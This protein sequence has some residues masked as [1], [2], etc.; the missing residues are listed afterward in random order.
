MADVPGAPREPSATH[1]HLL[2]LLF[3][4]LAATALFLLPLLRREVFVLRDHL[5]YFQPMRWFTATELRAGHLPLWNP[6]NSSGEPW[7]ANPQTGVFY[8]PAW[9]FVV[10]PFATAYV[11]FLLAHLILLGW[12]AY[13]LFARKASRSAALMGAT[14][15]MFCGPVVSLLDIST[16]LT[17]LAWFPLVLWCA[18]ERAW[19]RGGIVLALAFLAGEP[20]FAAVAALL[21]GFAAIA[22]AGSRS[23]APRPVTGAPSRAD[24]RQSA[25]IIARGLVLSALIAFGLSAV[26]LL[27]FLA[28][29]RGSDRASGFDAATILEYS[30]RLEDWL[31]VAMPPRFGIAFDPAVG[32]RFIPLVYIGVVVCALALAGIRRR[33]AGWVILFV[34]AVAVSTGP[35]WLVS[36][37]LTIFRYPARVVPLAALAL[38]ALAVAGYDRVRRGRRW[39][40]VAVVLVVMADLAPRAWPL[41]RSAPFRT[42]IVPYSRNVGAD[43]KILRVGTLDPSRRAAWISGYLN[44]YDRRFEAFT[45][46]PVASE[47]SVA[48]NIRLLEKPTR[49]ELAQK[50]VGW[51]VTTRNLS[52]AFARAE[53]ADGV[54]VY[55]NQLTFP[56]AALVVR[57]PLTLIPA[58]VV[59]D[60]SHAR[61]TVDAPREGVV[62][63]HQQDAPGWDV[64]VDGVDARSTVHGELFR[65]VQITRGPHVVEWSYR[66]G[67]LLAGAWITLLTQLFLF[68]S[69][70]VKRTR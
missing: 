13:L 60:T 21:Y 7:L 8:P 49:E 47:R 4:A 42:D 45:A 16:I 17:T 48:M 46:A 63:L 65:A 36:L 29:V 15:L 56:M 10:L 22:Q 55:R 33:T 5:D 12:G 39:L 54:T 67:A 50:A 57:N 26:Q 27:P 3:L 11:L 32:Q 68:L 70:F 62:L 19:R 18:C 59:F 43:S 35:H 66:P 31:H 6:Y 14:A 25:G 44:L 34:C 38:V 52:P 61:V 30:M 64:T 23:G 51:V 28:W 58:R 24:N 69:A 20:F 2:P 1:R 41:L 40:D 53:S 37:P 9:L